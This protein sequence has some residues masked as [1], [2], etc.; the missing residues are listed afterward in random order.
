MLCEQGSAKAG[1]GR[2]RH[3]RARWRQPGGRM[4]TGKQGGVLCMMLHPRHTTAN[5]HRLWGMPLR[6]YHCLGPLHHR[7]RHA[8][9]LLFLTRTVAGAAGRCFASAR[10]TAA[11]GGLL[12]S[13]YRLQPPQQGSQQQQY[14]KRA[15]HLAPSY[16]SFP[17]L[18][19]SFPLS[20]GLTHLYDE[21]EIWLA[22]VR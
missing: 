8:V 3:H 12:C 2:A 20:A 11:A 17:L 9:Q 14:G 4:P 16:H 1:V 22:E 5:H 6:R 7:E 19:S 10:R 15:L 18:S 21:Q 13:A